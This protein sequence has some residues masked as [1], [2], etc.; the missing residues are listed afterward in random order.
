MLDKE[1]P[2]F[3]YNLTF[4]IMS[5]SYFGEET[6]TSNTKNIA[7][8]GT[9]KYKI[10]DVQDGY[11]KL[12]KNSNWWNI[13]NKNLTLEKITINKYATLG[14]LYNA[15]KIGNIDVV[16][17]ENESLQEYIGKIGYNPKELKGR[18]HGFLVFNT[19]NTILSQTEVRKAI[20]YSIDKEN[21]VSSIFNNS[22]YTSSFPLDYGTW[23]YQNQNSSA[24]YNPE[25]AKKVLEEAGWTYRN[26]NWQ[27]TVNYKTQKLI[28]NLLVKASDAT[29]VAVAENIKSQLSNQGIAVNIVQASD[30]QYTTMLNNKNFDI[31]LCNMYLSA[32]PSMESFFG[33]GNFANYNNNEAIEILKQ[34]KNT[35]EET[36]LKE[37][38]SK[39]ADIY[40]NDVPYISIYTNKYNVAYNATLSGDLEPNWFSSFY[41]I[42]GWSK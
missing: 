15:F 18:E 11:I 14:E 32:N 20:S 16:S 31:C 1:V 4:P 9:G 34:V 13:T 25:Q 3:E 28:L 33:D 39:L 17:T 41:N 42:E 5:S 27:K 8:I 26:K 37:R 2:F 21:I 6:F 38:Y 30:S 40:K 24:G 36:I 7:P 10:T 23:I 35:T 19:Q 29:R 12:E 22:Y